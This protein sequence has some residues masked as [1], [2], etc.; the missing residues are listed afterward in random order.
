MQFT[1]IARDVGED[2]RAGRLYL[3]QQWLREVNIG[4]NAFLARPAFSSELGGII[5]RLLD[6]ADVLYA[7]AA[8]AIA[9]LPADCRPAIHAARVLYAEIGRELERQG[10]DSVSRRAVVPASR[11]FAVLLRSCAVPLASPYRGHEPA[12]RQTAFLIEAV[13]SA[14]PTVPRAKSM[15]WHRIRDRAIWV[16]DLFERLERRAQIERAG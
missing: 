8:L 1:N 13:D 9:A 7:R 11:K 3:P 2:A 4:P 6:H 14:L 5:Q 10:L 12:S 16:I 15:P